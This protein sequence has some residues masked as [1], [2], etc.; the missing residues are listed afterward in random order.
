MSLTLEVYSSGS[1]LLL[2]DDYHAATGITF[3]GFYP[4]GLF[5]TASFFVPRPPA[6][7]GL[8]MPGMRVKIRNGNVTVWEGYVSAR[9]LV[10]EENASGAQYTCL[11]AWGYLFEGALINKP[12]AD[13]RISGDVWLDVTAQHSPSDVSLNNYVSL[14]RQDRLHFTPNSTR[15]AAGAE[16]GWTTNQYHRITRTVPT[17]QTIKRITYNCD[18]QEGAQ[19]WIG[20]IFNGATNAAETTYT[21]SGTATADTTLGTPSQTIWIYLQ[22]GGNQSP[23]T[24]DTVYWEVTEMTEYTELGSINSTEIAKDIIPMV[25]GCST[26]ETGIGSNTLS[27]VPF[28]AENITAAQTLINAAAFGDS[29]YNSWA[30]YVEDSDKSPDDKPILYYAQQ[31]EL[32]TA[33]YYIRLEDKNLQPPVSLSQD[34]AEVRNW[35]S[36]RYTDID[37]RQVILSPDDDANLKDTTSIAA[38]GTRAEEITIDTT[39]ATL[40]ANYG[41]RYLASRKDPQWTIDSGLTIQGYIRNATEGHVPAANIRPG[42]RVRIENFIEDISGTGLTFLIT[43]T[44]YNDETQTNT[45]QIGRPNQLDVWL[46]RVTG[47]TK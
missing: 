16:T 1:T 40:A 6:R 26:A 25:T 29:S 45:L 13:N 20:G 39:S 8:I 2:A 23:P 10:T 11:G 36:V 32:T 33:E 44:D 42:E 14:D 17:G 43:G 18:L 19:A 22:S 37:G 4:G 21:S 3:D 31:P 34:T 38:Y 24:D 41:R 47:E 12:W 28:V 9:T 30:F 7:L 46:A 27:L 15:D 35:I 5:G